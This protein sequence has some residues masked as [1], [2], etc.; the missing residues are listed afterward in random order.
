MSVAVLGGFIQA[1]QN[2]RGIVPHDKDGR[3]HERRDVFDIAANGF[4]LQPR[5]LGRAIE[6]SCVQPAGDRQACSE[7]ILR[8]GTP[9][10]RSQIEQDIGQRIVIALLNHV[11]L[12]KGQL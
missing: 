4:R 3:K 12:G 9:V 10:M 5:T 7:S 2:E 6:Q 1:D 11:R 8:D